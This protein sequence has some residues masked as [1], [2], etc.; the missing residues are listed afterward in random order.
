MLTH[1]VVVAKTSA[2]SP[3]SS[4]VEVAP[5]NGLQ[6]MPWNQTFVS[7]HR[8]VAGH[9]WAPERGIALGRSVLCGPRQCV[10]RDTAGSSQHVPSSWVMGALAPKTRAEHHCITP[11]SLQSYSGAPQT[12]CLYLS[13]VSYP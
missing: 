13:F 7:P 11:W 10:V 5:Q 2:D 9:V 8:P 12:C 4:G 3:G 6:L 1:R